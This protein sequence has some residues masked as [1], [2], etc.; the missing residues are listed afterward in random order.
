MHFHV[1]ARRV[2]NSLIRFCACK[3]PNSPVELVHFVGGR[4]RVLHHSGP[5]IDCG[6][7]FRLYKMEMLCVSDP[8][9]CVNLRI[10]YRPIQFQDVVVRALVTLLEMHLIAVRITK[11]IDPGAFIVPV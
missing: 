1:E 9:L 3:I 10:G 5:A 2:R 8:R 4:A 7:V 6:D 11:M